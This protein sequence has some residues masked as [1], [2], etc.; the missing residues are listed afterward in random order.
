VVTGVGREVQPAEEQGP[1]GQLAHGLGLTP[2]PVPEHLGV[3]PGGGD[4]L[5]G[6]DVLLGAVDHGGEGGTA[7]V[8]MGALVVEGLFQG[9]VG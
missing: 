5:A 4:V 6:D 8:V 2:E 1:F 9:G 3:G 7:T